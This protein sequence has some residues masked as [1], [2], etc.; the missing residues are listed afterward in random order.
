[1]DRE[2]EIPEGYR[3]GMQTHGHSS[4]L[5]VSRAQ[6]LTVSQALYLVSLEP[7]KPELPSFS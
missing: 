2:A 1:M 3:K 6:V 4:Q 5:I 7:M